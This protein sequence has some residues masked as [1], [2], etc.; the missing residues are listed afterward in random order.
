MIH[1]EYHVYC[2]GGFGNHLLA[3]SSAIILSQYAKGSIFIY[4][5]AIPNDGD[6]KRNDTRTTIQKI[7]KNQPSGNYSEGLPIIDLHIHTV[8][9]YTRIH[10]LLKESCINTS[11]YTRIHIHT[12]TVMHL[13]EY[14]L[15]RTLIL[16]HLKL[17]TPVID[18]QPSDVVISFRLG[19]GTSETCPEVFTGKHRIPMA[20]YNKILHMLYEKE[21]IKRIIICADNFTDPYIKEFISLSI[22]DGTKVIYADYNT[23][24]QFQIILNAKTV[25]SSNS[26]FSVMGILLTNAD[27]VY[28]PLFPETNT[29]FNDIHEINYIL[30]IDPQKYHYITVNE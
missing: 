15:H 4:D 5:N 10:T 29:I 24:D 21:F 26:T 1:Y 25:I 17:P 9:D 2:Q 27:N 16:E 20:Y 8:Q 14:Y 19:M 22:R 23:F 30:D 28:M 7:I 12:I 3:Y 11:Q 6:I 18:L 13:N